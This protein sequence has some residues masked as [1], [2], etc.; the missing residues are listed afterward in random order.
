MFI[1]STLY[2]YFLRYYPNTLGMQKQ[3]P[4]SGSQFHILF[5][6]FIPTRLINRVF[7]RFG[8]ARR[9]PPIISSRELVMGLVFHFLAGFGTLAQHINQ[10]TGKS[11]SDSA[12]AQRR[13]AL[14]FEI[15]GTLLGESLHTRAKLTLHPEAFYKGLRLCGADGTLFSVANTPQVKGKMKKARTRRSRAAF[16]KVGVVVLLELGLHNPIAAAIDVRGKSEA[17]LAQQVIIELPPES[18]YLADRYH[19]NPKQLIGFRRTHPGGQREF[20]VRVRSNITSRVL[21]VYSDGS[22]LVELRSGKETLLVREITGRVRRGAGKWSD[23]RLWTSLLDWKKHPAGELLAL[24][25]RRWEQEV[26]YRELKVDM[27]SAKLVQSHTPVTAAQEIAA[28]ILG[29][30][31]L[32]E[33]RMKAAKVGEVEVLRISFVKTLQ[34]IRGLWNFLE[35]CDGILTP[36][37]V[38]KVVR[39]T[40]CMIAEMATPEKRAR[41]CPR[42]LRQPVSSWPRLRKN[43]YKFGVPNYEISAITA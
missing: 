23:V 2:L 8:P 34:A 37:Q 26:F 33:Q 7:R 29:Y 28:L 21:E 19:G 9:R 13:A 40:L 27:R 3:S 38:P 16:P 20:L 41:T 24:Y 43:T 12:L 30:A 32:V 22:G 36:K 11:I 14:D 15:F 18:L 1:I 6:L 5:R 39:R 31:M 10:L 42:Q 17:Y 25:A 4:L 35:V